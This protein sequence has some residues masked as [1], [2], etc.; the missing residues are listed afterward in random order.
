MCIFLFLPLAH[1]IDCVIEE[2]F[3]RMGAS[4]GYYHEDLKAIWDDLMELKPTCFV[5]VPRVF[6][7]VHEGILQALQ[8]LKPIRRNIFHLLYRYKLTRM[9]LRF[10]QKNYAPLAYLLALRKARYLEHMWVRAY[11]WLD[12]VFSS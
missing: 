5:G 11:L 4:V 10:K 1:I 12:H 8:E 9:N 3:F 6:E 2:D 7:R